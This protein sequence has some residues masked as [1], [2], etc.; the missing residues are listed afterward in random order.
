MP[1]MAVCALGSALLTGTDPVT[2]D[3]CSYLYEPAY[4]MDRVL[5][6]A[7]APYLPQ[8]GDI[9]LATDSNLFWTIGHNLAITGHPHH[10]GIVF[11]RPDG[12]M[13][14]LEAG[15]YDTLRVRT[16]DLIPHLKNY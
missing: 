13:A 2:R 8:P 15:P 7:P 5:R 11:A 6:G 3:V 14:V 1:W 4:C 16:L 10:S 9:M 12:R